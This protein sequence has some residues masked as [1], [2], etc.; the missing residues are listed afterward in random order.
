MWKSEMLWMNN[1]EETLL[2]KMHSLYLHYRFEFFWNKTGYTV[3]NIAFQILSIFRSMFLKIEN[4]SP[5]LFFGHQRI[6]VVLL[7]YNRIKASNSINW[8]LLI[9]WI[10]LFLLKLW[11][12]AIYR[13]TFLKID[14]WKS[15][16]LWM[17]NFE[18]TLFYRMHSL[19]L[20]YRFVFSRIRLVIPNKILHLK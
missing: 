2:Y 18:E 7:F 12:F 16:M 15:E 1:L 20:H 19:Y 8:H 14:T 17:N 4:Q 11:N 6:K 5:F 9:T 13:H 10:C 3:K